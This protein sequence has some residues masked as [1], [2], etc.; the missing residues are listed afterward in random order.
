MRSRNASNCEL[1]DCS[2]V[3]MPKTLKRRSQGAQQVGKTL[4]SNEF[5][6]VPT[7]RSSA[8]CRRQS[9]PRGLQLKANR[10]I[11]PMRGGCGLYLRACEVDSHAMG[12]QKS[13]DQL[14]PVRRRLLQLLAANGSNLR[15]ASLAIG[16]NAAYLH[17]FISRGH[18]ESP[19]RGRPRDSGPAS[20][21]QAGAAPARPERPP[22][23][24]VQAAA[25]LRPLLQRRRVSAPCRRPVSG[26]SRAREPGTVS[27]GRPATRGC[28]PIRSSATSS[29]PSPATC[30]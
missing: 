9:G 8:G 2:S 15:T 7:A 14:D 21:M 26:W 18:A 4:R 6:S 13:T 29:G 24:A 17:Q 11:V 27:C 22:Q 10:R 1:N 3:F 20:G 25:T 30:G 12:K 5:Q 23:G 28:S 19:G 16:R